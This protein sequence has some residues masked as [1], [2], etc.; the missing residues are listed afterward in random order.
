MFYLHI[1]YMTLEGWSSLAYILF[2]H[3]ASPPTYS[4]APLV[5]R[6]ATDL[7][8]WGLI[9]LL[10]QS[11]GLSDFLTQSLATQYLDSTCVTHISRLI[12]ST[13]D[14]HHQVSAI[15]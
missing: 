13:V 8:S 15:P 6:Q 9:D 10:K 5:H 11:C 2:T 3:I 12:V 14:G 4:C 7:Q 1:V